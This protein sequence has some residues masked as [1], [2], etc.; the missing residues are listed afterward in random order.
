MAAFSDDVAPVVVAVLA[1]QLAPFR[2]HTQPKLVL[3]RGRLSTLAA[4]HASKPAEAFLTIHR[5]RF[6]LAAHTALGSLKMKVIRNR[7]SGWSLGVDF[8]VYRIEQTQKK[9]VGVCISVSR[10]AGSM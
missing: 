10:N 1:N 2:P 5:S 4:R 8:V 7:S 3:R 9:F 6:A